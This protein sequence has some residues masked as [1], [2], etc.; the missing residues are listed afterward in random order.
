M[1]TN[2]QTTLNIN[3]FAAQHSMASE[4]EQARDLL[5]VLGTNNFRLFKAQWDGNEYTALLTTDEI[6]NMSEGSL[7]GNTQPTLADGGI[8]SLADN[9]LHLHQGVMF[10]LAELV[11]DNEAT[12][13]L[14]V[15]QVEAV[16]ALQNFVKASYDEET[17][18]AAVLTLA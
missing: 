9:G 6:T 2:L 3:A 8:A 15:P 17:P 7:S 10:R 13:S 4:P 14:T 5:E 12:L 18:F 1:F 16:T 11:E